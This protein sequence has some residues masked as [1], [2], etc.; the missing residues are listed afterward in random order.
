MKHDT[1]GMRTDELTADQLKEMREDLLR[2]YCNLGSLVLLKGCDV[3]GGKRR[4]RD[5]AMATIGKYVF[6]Q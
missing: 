5:D 2:I 1:R 4:T 6:K 3:S